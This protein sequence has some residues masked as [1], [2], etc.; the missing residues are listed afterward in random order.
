MEIQFQNKNYDLPENW[1]IDFIGIVDIN[2]K[3]DRLRKR[4]EET[5]GTYNPEYTNRVAFSHKNGF[6]GHA[7]HDRSLKEAIK[8]AVIHM[9]FYDEGLKDSRQDL[10][11][12]QIQT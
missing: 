5:G 1:T 4:A 7:T 2:P 12:I 9:R 3:Q 6:C 10:R 8:S 11:E